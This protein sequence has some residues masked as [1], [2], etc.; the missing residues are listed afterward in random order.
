ML[1]KWGSEYKLSLAPKSLVMLK[2]LA[3]WFE[4]LQYLLDHVML[5]GPVQAHI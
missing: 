1:K 4:K 2:I 3:K 5:G